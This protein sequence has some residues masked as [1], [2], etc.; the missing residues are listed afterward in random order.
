MALDTMGVDV[1][2]GDL[3]AALD[4]IMQGSITGR[5]VVDVRR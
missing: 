1:A 3:D 2:L 4:G 5:S